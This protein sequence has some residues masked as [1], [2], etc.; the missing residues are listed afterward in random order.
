S[1]G[2]ITHFIAIKRDITHRKQLEHQLNQAHRIEGI[3]RLAGGV[4]HDFNTLL[5]VMNGTVELAMARKIDD[6]VM[7]QDLKT[8]GD[9]VSRGAKLT[10][11][12]LAVSRQQVLQPTVVDLNAVVRE[13]NQMLSRLIGERTTI[14]LHLQQDLA[15]IR[16]DAGQLGQVLMNLVVNARDAMPDGGEVVVT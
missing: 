1:H 3:G 5:T 10:R 14:T 11:Q 8:I 4:A 6:A 16:A 7:A 9:A 15:R 12:L 2:E 13:M